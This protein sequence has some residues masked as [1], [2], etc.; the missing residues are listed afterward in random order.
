LASCALGVF[1]S[2]AK[3]ED[4]D[5]QGYLQKDPVG[6]MPGVALRTSTPR[7]RRC[8]RGSHAAAGYLL[9]EDEAAA[10]HELEAQ[11]PEDFQ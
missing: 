6:S 3:S 11:L 1:A 9:K 7:P 4:I 2:V 10:I 5:P 8:R